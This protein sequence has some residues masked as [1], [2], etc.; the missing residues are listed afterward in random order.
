M[1]RSTTLALIIIFLLLGT[2][3][4]LLDPSPAVRTVIGIAMAACLML[5]LVGYATYGSGSAKIS[6][7]DLLRKESDQQR[8]TVTNIINVVCPDVIDEEQHGMR[9]QLNSSAIL[10]DISEYVGGSEIDRRV[11]LK[12]VQHD[13]N[14]AEKYSLRYP[15]HHCYCHDGSEDYLRVPLVDHNE[16]T[17]GK[18]YVRQM[19]EVP[20]SLNAQLLPDN[21]NARATSGQVDKL[22]T[23]DRLG[24]ITAEFYSYRYYEQFYSYDNIIKDE[25]VREK[26]IRSLFLFG[27]ASF[28]C[29]E[30]MMNYQDVLKLRYATYSK[31]NPKSRINEP[32]DQ[33]NIKPSYPTYRSYLS[34]SIIKSGITFL[35][36]LFVAMLVGNYVLKL[37]IPVFIM[38]A[39]PFPVLIIWYSFTYVM[40]HL[41][42]KKRHRHNASL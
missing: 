34:D 12:Q 18:Y 3:L 11:L 7:A 22:L 10:D 28:Y 20:S 23:F 39:I 21:F 8:D 19:H 24:N 25:L 5:L 14:H 26:K 37:D 30:D 13:L 40:G 29:S 27:E 6:E 41:R 36:V 1:T 4:F 42:W 17:K 15:C 9:Q 16:L 33:M 35:A 38:Y 2:G 32:V 31:I